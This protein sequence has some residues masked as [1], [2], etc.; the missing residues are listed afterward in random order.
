MTRSIRL[1]L[2]AAAACA[3]SRY[4]S[5]ARRPDTSHHRTRSPSGSTRHD[6]AECSPESRARANRLIARSKVSASRAHQILSNPAPSSAASNNNAPNHRSNLNPNR[7]NCRRATAASCRRSVHY[8]QIPIAGTAARAQY[9]AGSFPGGFR[10]TA[11]VPVAA[12]T[13]GPS[14]ETHHN[15]RLPVNISQIVSNRRREPPD[16]RQNRSPF[17]M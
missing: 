5:A 7:P 2:A 3:S 17:L 1:A 6:E 9:P 10:T 13:M 16:L 12:P 15:T 11:P 4:S 14:S 8:S